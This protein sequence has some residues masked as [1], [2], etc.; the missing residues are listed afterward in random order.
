MKAVLIQAFG[1]PEVLDYASVPTPSPAA[2]EV[3]IQVHAV[4][5]N[6]M[7]IDVREG[8]SGF[9]FP[10]PHV[11]GGECAGQIV[12]AGSAVSGYSVGDRVMP[13]PS[14]SSGNCR[15]ARCNCML[16][17][18]NLCH[19]FGKLGISCWGSYAGYV[20][21]GYQNLVRVPDAL[22]YRQAAAGRTTF[23]TAWEL[24]VNQGQVRQ[25]ETVLINGAGGAVGTA[26][27]LVAQQAGA[28]VICSVGSAERE[29][30]LR[31]LGV[32]DIVNYHNGDM[33]GRVM[34]LTDGH[35]VD[36]AIDTVGGSVLLA[37]LD[38]MALGGRVAIGGAHAG[39]TVT[40]DIIKLF[41]K[42][43]RIVT[44]HSYPK[45]TTAAVFDLMARGR[46]EQIVAAEFELKHAA[47]AHRLISSRT[48]FGKVI[49]SV[50][51][52]DW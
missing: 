35:G 45:A 18:D 50:G 21:V 20:R 51:S 1:G 26:A 48:A 5:V 11:M 9:Q 52:E 31:G 36:L 34:E 8:R 30:K 12:A 44:T 3:L 23:S 39:E 15:H 42:Q 40:I 37:T 33:A 6:H 28:R 32:I 49:M 4:G 22:S 16:G 41:R 38:A 10:L 19:E 13:A 29:E 25:G 2:H 24:I 27:V 14:L 17:R 47:R 46:F 7:E 43:I